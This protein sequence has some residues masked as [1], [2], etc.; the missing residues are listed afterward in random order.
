[1]PLSNPEQDKRKAL[2]A[3]DPLVPL[4]QLDPATDL[5]NPDTLSLL[6]L[7]VCEVP[8]ESLALFRKRLVPP[9]QLRQQVAA[10]EVELQR[11]MLDITRKLE[12]MGYE[13]DSRVARGSKTGQVITEVADR[14]AVNLVIL[15]RRRQKNWQRLLVGSVADYVARHIRQPLLIMPYS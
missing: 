9:S 1:M 5:I 7:M 2:Y 11:H 13:V 3:V 10:R 4:D 12:S 15:Q 6:V 14:E 8:E